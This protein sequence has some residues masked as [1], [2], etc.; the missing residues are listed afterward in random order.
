MMHKRWNVILTVTVL[1]ISPAI[2]IA[3]A[4]HGHH[5]GTDSHRHRI[6]LFLGNTHDQGEDEFTG[7]LTYE[8]R[9]KKLIGIGALWESVAGDHREWIL[10]V[11]LF[12]H[13]YKGWRFVVAPGVQHDRRDRGAELLIRVGAAYE[14]EFGRWTITPT[15]NADYVN[16]IGQ[17]YVYGFAFGWGF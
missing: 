4:E 15:F 7:G 2:S 12:I 8:Y 1:I 10:G 14:F 11:P 5:E 3:A 6:E 9:V 16:N 13:P 17:V